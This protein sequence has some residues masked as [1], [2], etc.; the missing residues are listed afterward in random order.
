MEGLDTNVL[1]RYLVQDDPAQSRLASELMEE[2][3]SADRPGYINNVVLCELMWVLEECYGQS[4]SQLLRILNQLLCV[5]ELRFQNV[6]VV[7]LA[8]AD[9]RDGKADFSD[10]LIARWNQAHGCEQ[11]HTFDKKASK[12][13]GFVLLAK[14]SGGAW[15]LT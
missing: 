15:P 11:T 4:R 7:R 8:V 10:H 5:V 1:V 2:R 3:L 13:P 12:E 6:D 9:F 14:S